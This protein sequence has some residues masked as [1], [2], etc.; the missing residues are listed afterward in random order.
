MESNI[1]PDI[2]EFPNPPQINPPQMWGVGPPGFESGNFTT[3]QS[4]ASIHG[5]PVLHLRTAPCDL[6]PVTCVVFEAHAARPG[7]GNH[8]RGRLSCFCKLIAVL[9]LFCTSKC[10]M[11][12]HVCWQPQRFALQTNITRMTHMRAPA[13]PADMLSPC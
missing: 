12:M 9:C 13:P 8:L 7:I 3:F 2:L 5:A 10:F 6:F 11:Q 4:D 1:F